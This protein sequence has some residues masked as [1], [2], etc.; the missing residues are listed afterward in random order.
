MERCVDHL[1]VIQ[2][3]ALVAL[4]GIAAHVAV[5]RRPGSSPGKAFLVSRSQPGR[6]G[7]DNVTAT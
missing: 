4:A 7:G 5:L 6:P 1:T 2:I 3:L